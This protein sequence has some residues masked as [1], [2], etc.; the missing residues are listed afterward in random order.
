MLSL[1]VFE[2][3]IWLLNTAGRELISVAIILLFAN[4]FVGL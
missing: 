4:V 1:L 3:L 2:I